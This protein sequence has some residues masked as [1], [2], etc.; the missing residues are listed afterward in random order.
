MH[1]GIHR[2][3]IVLEDYSILPVT[4]FLGE[5]ASAQVFRIGGKMSSDEEFMYFPDEHETTDP[6]QFAKVCSLEMDALQERDSLDRAQAAFSRAGLEHAFPFDEVRLTKTFRGEHVL[7]GRPVLRKVGAEELSQAQWVHLLKTVQALG[8]AGLVHR[9]VRPSNFS[10][11]HPVDG[12]V[13]LIDYGFATADSGSGGYGKA[14]WISGTVTYAAEAVLGDMRLG[15]EQNLPKH[16]HDLESWVKC[17]ATH[18]LGLHAVWKPLLREELRDHDME[19]WRLCDKAGA[20]HAAWTEFM[21]HCAQNA[22]GVHEKVVGLLQAARS[23]N[24]G[25]MLRLVEQGLDGA[26]EAGE[27]G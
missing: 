1:R 7:M 18:G 19:S 27:E 2:K 11:V 9:D 25:E 23:G 15:M 16:V 21:R 6:P 24:H 13:R 17:Y 5:G 26:A 4:C 10:L 12:M 8:E 14:C 22:S 3:S 20:G